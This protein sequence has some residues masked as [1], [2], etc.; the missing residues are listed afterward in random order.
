MFF[1]SIL[2]LIAAIVYAV[3]L[4]PR[5]VVTST[6]KIVGDMQLI[7]TDLA[8]WQSI[9]N[10]FTGTT[11]VSKLPIQA[12]C[13][14]RAR[15]RVG[16]ILPVRAANTVILQ[17]QKIEFEQA[18]ANLQSAAEAALTDTQRLPPLNATDSDR[19][20]IKFR[21]LTPVITAAIEILGTKVT[22]DA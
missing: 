3:P 19:L 9:I 20:T 8:A 1:T 18:V 7:S 14:D 13:I 11:V 17:Q 6:P 22:D 15:S 2:A 21:D 10:P 5:Q 16:Y 12:F 4:T